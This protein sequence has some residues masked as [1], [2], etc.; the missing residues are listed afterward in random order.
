MVSFWFY[1]SS[2]FWL[3]LCKSKWFFLGET[4]DQWKKAGYHE[5]PEYANFTQLLEAPV[6]DAAEILQSRFPVPRYITTEQG[7]SQARFLLCK[8]NPSQTHNNSMFGG[9]SVSVKKWYKFLIP[10][11]QCFFF[12]FLIRTAVPQ[13]WPMTWVYKCLWSIWKNYQFRHKLDQKDWLGNNGFLC[14]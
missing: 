6:T 14:K 9:G 8:V 7:G 13:F 11:N 10:D 1:K 4:I 2:N 5:L 3:H 12:L